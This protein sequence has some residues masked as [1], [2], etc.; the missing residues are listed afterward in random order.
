MGS[1]GEDKEERK[2]KKEE[3]T[4]IKNEVKSYQNH[5]ME[6]ENTNEHKQIPVNNKIKDENTNDHKQIPVNIQLKNEV[7]NE[8]K[9]AELKN[10]PKKE[11]IKENKQIP[12]DN[13]LKN[14]VITGYK[15]IPL[16][17]LNKILK[18]VCKITI[19]SERG[20]NFGKGFFIN[21][22]DTLKLLLT[23]YHVINPSLENE[24]IE[25]EIH[26][27]KVMKLELKNRFCKYIE[28]PKDITIIEIKESD[29]IYNDIEF[30]DYDLNFIKNGY[31]IYKD[32][33]IFS[34]VNPHGDDASCSS[35]KLINIYEYD[36]DHDISTNSEAVGCPILLLNNNIDLIKVMGI[37]KNL[38][39][40][41]KL[42][43]GIFIGEIFKEKLDLENKEKTEE[44][45]ENENI[46]PKTDK[47]LNKNSSNTQIPKEE[48]EK[49]FKE[50][51]PLKD[52][53]DVKING[54]IKD[55]DSI[56]LGEWD[57]S[58][59]EKHGRGIQY[60]EEGTKYYGYFS[61]NK[62]NIKG[63]LIYNNGDIYEGEFLDGLANGKGKYI[64]IDGNIY[65]GDWKNDEKN[66]KGKEQW[67]DGSFYEGDY[68]NGQK[69]GNGKFIWPDGSSYEGEYVDNVINGYGYFIF[70]DKRTYTGN[71][72]NQNLEGKG[73]STWPDGRKYEGEYKNNKKEGYGTYYWPGGKIYKGYWKNGKQD[74]DGEYY[75]PK[76]K[77]WK[78]GHWENGERIKWY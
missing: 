59:N 2:V 51:P 67:S 52:G 41:K 26:N 54:P 36:F 62:E 13:Q 33:D 42:N 49:L 25:I 38:E 24:N 20:S 75:N 18:S 78:K 15:P 23:N 28:E 7:D 63:K 53:I 37:M 35:G 4:E 14:E 16:E 17:I 5:Q 11:E 12:V 44:K 57:F 43:R 60:F 31:S 22:S 29:E 21:Y 48:L 56:Y 72:V 27:K 70:A 8:N 61:Q 74:G 34:V 66:G 3:K 76:N 71:W 47:N 1:C 19:K 6:N 32:V 77:T 65:E 46:V 39:G 40:P 50:Y 64:T 30:L 9:K 58:K 73:V 10:Q 45:K 69:H 55:N 68:L